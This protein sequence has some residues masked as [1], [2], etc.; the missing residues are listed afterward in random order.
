MKGNQGN[1]A[2]EVEALFE[3]ADRVGYKGFT[4]DF[5]ETEEKN[6]GRQE[7]RRYWSMACEGQLAHA[8]PW[9]KLNMIGMVESERTLEGK[10]TL[11]HRYYI[12]SIETDARLFAKGA[13][14]HW[15]VE[16][17]LHWV[18]D[19]A[20]REDDSRI[21]TGHA[22]ENFALLRHIAVNAIKQEKTAK[23]GVKNKRLKAGWDE[24]Y[25]AKILLGI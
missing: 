8:K 16:N 7:V 15:G 10:S 24:T 3:K 4:V 6:H 13:R 25:L 14:G 1:L 19:V 20:F 23:L 11:E 17:G 5:H 12:G 2:K 18:L 9:V 21:R 22:P